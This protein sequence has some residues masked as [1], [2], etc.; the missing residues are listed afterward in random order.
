MGYKYTDW[1][2]L[3]VG[4]GARFRSR[5]SVRSAMLSGVCTYV[6]MCMYMCIWVWV[7]SLPIR[8]VLVGGVSLN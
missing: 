2:T 1:D 8:G 7:Y 5:K 3:P 4:L 6:Y